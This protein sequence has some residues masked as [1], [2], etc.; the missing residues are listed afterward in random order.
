MTVDLTKVPVFSRSQDGGDDDDATYKV[1]IADN[2]N[3][4]T[5]IRLMRGVPSNQTWNVIRNYAL[6][7]KINDFLVEGQCGMYG[8][9]KYD[10]EL[11]DVMCIDNT[12]YSKLVPA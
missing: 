2:I 5:A 1:H 9:Y 11:K 8:V 6:S 10:A 4:N 7:N 12:F 3:A